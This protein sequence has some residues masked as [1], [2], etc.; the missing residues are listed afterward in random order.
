[1]KKTIV[2]GITMVTGSAG[3]LA[4]GSSLA[5]LIPAVLAG[6][7]LVVALPLFV[8]FLFLWWSAGEKEG[9]IP[10]MGY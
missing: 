2:Q 10:F 6:A 5:G 8:L 9:D 7:I 4:E 1:M 3:L